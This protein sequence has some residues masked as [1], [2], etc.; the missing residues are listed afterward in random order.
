[1]RMNDISCSI[2]LNL[3][4]TEEISI[5]LIHNL[6]HKHMRFNCKVG[7]VMIGLERE[8]SLNLIWNGIDKSQFLSMSSMVNFRV[9][10]VKVVTPEKPLDV[11]IFP[12]IPWCQFY[13]L[14]C[15]KISLCWY[16]QLR[17][18]KILYVDLDDQSK[19]T[20]C[21][22]QFKTH[23]ALSP[24]TYVLSLSPQSAIY[25]SLFLCFLPN[26]P[27]CFTCTDST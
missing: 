19:S 12:K 7:T 8:I 11:N 25:H 22:P 2:S 5:K 20:K 3:I 4:Y 10:R 23:A 21:W 18:P 6:K 16:G 14:H 27:L 26:S 9:I 13:Y 24:S 15:L 1:M 17:Y